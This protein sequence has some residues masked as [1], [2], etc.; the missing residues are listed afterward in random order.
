M[1]LRDIKSSRYNVDSRIISRT[2]FVENWI[3][4]EIDNLVYDAYM[5]GRH[6]QAIASF[7]QCMRHWNKTFT[8]VEKAFYLLLPPEYHITEENVAC[9]SGNYM[10]GFYAGKITAIR[11]IIQ[12]MKEEFVKATEIL[13]TDDFFNNLYHAA[14]DIADDDL[15]QF[16]WT[17]LQKEKAPPLFLKEES[18]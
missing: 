14:E 18:T 4:S 13:G 5:Q 9:Y 17:Y 6:N 2:D 3:A 1:G 8:E 7:F 15:D 12:N 10:A 11:E 16:V